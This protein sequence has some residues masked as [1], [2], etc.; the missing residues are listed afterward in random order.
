M[1][2]KL[3]KISLKLAALTDFL[4]STFKYC[5]NEE[6]LSFSSSELKS[7]AFGCSSAQNCSIVF[8]DSMFKLLNEISTEL[9]AIC[10]QRK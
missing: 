7:A 2:C 10:E 5:R 6:I 3:I 1:F 8:V 4:M 9:S